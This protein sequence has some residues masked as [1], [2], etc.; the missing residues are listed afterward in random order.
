M[1]PFK[2]ISLPYRRLIIITGIIF[3]STAFRNPVYTP[4]YTKKAAVQLIQLPDTIPKTEVSIN[5]DFDKLM[6]DVDLALSKIDFNQIGKSVELSLKKIDFEKMQ[7]DIDAS[8]KSIDWEK[9]NTDIKNTINKVDFDKIKIEIDK[10]MEQ[11]KRQLNSKEFH[12]SMQKLKEKD[13]KEMKEELRKAK[14]DVEKSREELKKQLQKMKEEADEKNAALDYYFG[15]R[16]T[17]LIEI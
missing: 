15:F 8:L 13:M 17:G 2:L 4:V 14:I 6:A 11:A 16:K 5:I 7:K 10:G 3:I 12:Q 9:V 1:K